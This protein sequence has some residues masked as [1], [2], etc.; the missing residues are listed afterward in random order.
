MLSEA[1]AVVGRQD[2]ERVIEDASAFQFSEKYAKFVVQICQA[3][4]IAVEQ[5]GSIMWG[6]A[7][8]VESAPS[9]EELEIGGRVRLQAESI[10]CSG[11]QQIPRMRI[12]VI[13]K[14]EKRTTGR[15]TPR[16]PV[17]KISIDHS[18]ILFRLS[19]K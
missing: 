7:Q 17:Q 18:R 12:H 8:L 15:R 9:L 6:R 19:G 3:I 11:G 1:F 16:Q 2:H 4:V 5:K 13:K 14:R 10:L